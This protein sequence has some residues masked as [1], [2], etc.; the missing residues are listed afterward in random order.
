MLLEPDLRRVPRYGSFQQPCAAVH[1]YCTWRIRDLPLAG[2]PEGLRVQL[3]R[4]ACSGCSRRAERSYG[5]GHTSLTPRLA[6]GKR[7]TNPTFN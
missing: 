6:E 3:R 2:Y 7:S 1:K 4:P 5:R